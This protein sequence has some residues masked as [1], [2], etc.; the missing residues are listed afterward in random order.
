MKNFF[1]VIVSTLLLSFNAFAQSTK[2]L[3]TYVRTS[4]D[5]KFPGAQKV[6]WSKENATEW[7]AEFKMGA[8]EYSANFNSEGLW[9]E[10]EY[11]IG[12]NEIPA[13]VTASLGKEFPGYKLVESEV[14]ETARGKV[15]ELTIKTGT[16][17]TE[18]A[19]DENG[20]IQK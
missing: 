12:A 17:K 2:D 5:Q 20:V 7:E 1:L 10:T 4:F 6:K 13:A 16:K 9:V 15:Y 19:F 14:S 11:K 8:K 18:I 3:P